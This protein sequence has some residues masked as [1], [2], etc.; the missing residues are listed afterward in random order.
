LPWC[1]RILARAS[2]EQ[3]EAVSTIVITKRTGSLGRDSF[4][5]V[6]V[7]VGELWLGAREAIGIEGRTW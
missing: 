5:A 2:C 1:E 7:R 4:E 6:L 3:L